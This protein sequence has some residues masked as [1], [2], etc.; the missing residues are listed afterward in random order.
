MSRQTRNQR[1]KEKYFSDA[2]KSCCG[3]SR[4]KRFFRCVC[5]GERESVVGKVGGV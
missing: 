3:I 4:L 5:V 2:K 1:I